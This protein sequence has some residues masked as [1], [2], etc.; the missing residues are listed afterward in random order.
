[1]VATSAAGFAISFSHDSFTH[2]QRLSAVLSTPDAISVSDRIQPDK[3]TAALRPAVGAIISEEVNEPV[4][5]VTAARSGP[6]PTA[7]TDATNPVVFPSFG[8]TSPEAPAVVSSQDRSLAPAI[9][10]IRPHMR[11]EQA[12]IAASRPV[13][14][15]PDRAVRAELAP[16]AMNLPIYSYSPSSTR[17]VVTTTKS[18][19]APAPRY[20]IGVYR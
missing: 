2:Q 9:A 3:T 10:T 15:T 1:M 20:L 7:A 17:P 6:I 14:A 12:D 5:T 13:T 11:N 18:K 8:T 19:A 16:L 4:R